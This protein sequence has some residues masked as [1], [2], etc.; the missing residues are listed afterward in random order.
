ML[1]KMIISKI[2]VSLITIVAAAVTLAAFT[3]SVNAHPPSSVAL[4][5][6]SAGQALTV[7]VTHSPF[8]DGSHYINV[9]EIVKNGK[10]IDKFSYKDQ[11]GETFTRTFALPAVDGD[12]LEAKAT[13][14]KYGSLTGKLS[15]G[16]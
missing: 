1:G 15:V 11:P 12:V 9:I 4:Q 5:Y 2:S 6:D 10:T 8:R 14:S 16:K 13:C 3:V 7:M